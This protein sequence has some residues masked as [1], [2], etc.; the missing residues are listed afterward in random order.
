VLQDG[1]NIGHAIPA[2][3]I[4]RFLVDAEDGEIAGVPQLG[5]YCLPIENDALRRYLRMGEHQGGSI[6]ADVAYGSCAWGK[7]KRDDVILAVDGVPVAND[8]TIPL[9][10]SVRADFFCAIEQKQIGDQVAL[11]I[12]RDAREQNVSLV[13]SDYNLLVSQ[14]S[15]LRRCRYRI[16]GGIVFQ[17]VDMHCVESMLGYGPPTVYDAMVMEKPQTDD[18][19][20]IVAITSVLPHPVN[21]GYQDWDWN[22]VECVRGIP[23]RDFEHFNQLLDETEGPWIELTLDDASRLVIDR[24]AARAADEELFENFG[25]SA[26]RW[27]VFSE[28]SLAAK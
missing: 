3:M 16:A 5:A 10:G 28:G 14:P 13:L 7:I 8:C 12:W 17:P 20:E 18:R 26:D 9:P 2:P 1:E 4:E 21:R 11:T 23:V 27:P 25:I 15:Y 24:E 19:R 6:V 22:I